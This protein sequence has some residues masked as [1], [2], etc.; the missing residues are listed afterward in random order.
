MSAKIPDSHDHE[1][2]D[3]LIYHLNPSVYLSTDDDYALLVCLCPY[4]SPCQNLC[5]DISG[6]TTTKQKEPEKVHA[7][8]LAGL[9]LSS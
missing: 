6:N 1:K 8:S 5:L 7:F 9:L 3:V 2:S 4:H